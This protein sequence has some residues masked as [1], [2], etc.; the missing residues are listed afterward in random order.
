[1]EFH[2]RGYETGDPRIRPA[3]GL[4]L[5]RSPNIPEKLDALIVGTGPAGALLG[6]Q[7]SHFPSLNVRIIEKRASRLEVGQAD[8]IQARSVETFEAFGFADEIIKEAYQI[9]ETRFWKPDP[10]NPTAIVRTATTADDGA[11]LSE[12]PHIVI[13]QARLIDYLIEAGE[14]GPGRIAPDYGVEFVGLTRTDDPEYPVTVTLRHTAGEPAGQEFTV[15]A[16]YVVGADG[17]RSSVR[18]AIGRTLK[19][20]T[21]MHAWGVMDVLA[22]TDFPDANIKCAIQSHDGGN[23]L[24][25]PREGGYLFRVYVDLGVTAADD[26]GRVRETPLDEIIRRANMIL[27]P[28]FLDVKSVGWW[29]VYEVAHRL[30]DGFDDAS[31]RGDGRP[32]QPRVFLMGDACHTHSAKAG[33]GMNVSMQDAFNLGWKLGSV[34]EGRAPTPLLDTYA[35]ERRVIA[36]HLI[37]FDREWSGLMA[38]P[39]EDLADPGALERFY[40]EAGEF[41]NG[42]KTEYPTSQIVLG[43]EHQELATGFPVGKR[44]HSAKVVRRSDS[45]VVHLGHLHT[46][47]GRWRVYVFADAPAPGEPDSEAERLAEWLLSAPGSPIVAHTPPGAEQDAVFDV[48]V[49]YQQPF[50]EVE[51]ARVPEVF[52][53]KRLPLGLTNNNKVFAAGTVDKQS[54]DIFTERGVSRAGAV[55]IVRPDMYV[56]GVLPLTARQELTAYFAGH[57]VRLP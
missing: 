2:F 40:V 6:A 5:T 17:A 34:L 56:A 52:R 39:A 53:P 14:R 8:G 29:S 41:S 13:N 12:F 3:E 26:N 38:T 51:H 4:G 1:M 21:S 30:A 49:I 33:Q 16:K 15:H 19:G 37:D 18:R 31:P 36:Q 20:D 57:L 24:L 47:D 50:T 9:T 42:F 43:T 25:I 55:V 27:S 10:Q 22:E 7:L 48:K 45:N 28:Y 11:D 44:F 32:E 46:A 35:A 54:V 23:I